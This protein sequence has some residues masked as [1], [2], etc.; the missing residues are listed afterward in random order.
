MKRCKRT[1][2]YFLSRWTL[3]QNQLKNEQCFPNHVIQVIWWKSLLFLW[4]IYCRKQ[5]IEKSVLFNII[6]LFFRPEKL[7]TTIEM[8]SLQTT[9][10]I[11][12]ST[13]MYSLFPLMSGRQFPDRFMHQCS[14][15]F[16]LSCWITK[17][18]VWTALLQ[19]LSLTS[20][21]NSTG[22]T[23]EEARDWATERKED[24][25]GRPFN[26]PRPSFIVSLPTLR[27]W[28]A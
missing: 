15:L 4:N 6:E 16:C 10:V 14:Q 21:S 7:S 3:L 28:K 26:Y 24:M 5:N 13:L 17:E 20:F 11:F 19:Q 9:K 25:K 1:F 2:F 18:F 12:L 27:C 22:R 23:F 8:Y